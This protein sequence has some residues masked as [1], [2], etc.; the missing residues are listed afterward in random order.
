MQVNFEVAQKLLEKCSSFSI[1]SKTNCCSGKQHHLV[2]KMSISIYYSAIP[3]IIIANPF[4]KIAKGIPLPPKIIGA[5]PKNASCLL[6]LIPHFYKM[7]WLP[8]YLFSPLFLNKKGKTEREK[9]SW[10]LPAYLAW[11][12]QPTE[13]PFTCSLLRVVFP[14]LGAYG[15]RPL[16]ATEPEWLN[17]GDKGRLLHS[18]CSPT[19]FLLPYPGSRSPFPPSDRAQQS[20]SSVAAAATGVPECRSR[21]WRKC[22]RL[23]LPSL[24]SV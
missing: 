8:N 3:A 22:R 9:G 11:P 15:G 4:M 6:G 17:G 12:S 21:A 13:A 18:P 7:I 24:P 19:P 1:N 14:A 2:A 16:L 20:L 5:V 10:A 23:L